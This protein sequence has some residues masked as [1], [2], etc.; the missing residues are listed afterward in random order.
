MDRS[1]VGSTEAV[2]A[3]E[4]WNLAAGQDTMNDHGWS[5]SGV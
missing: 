4:T 2:C 1:K 5:I 3:A